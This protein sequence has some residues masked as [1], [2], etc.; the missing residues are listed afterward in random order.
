MLEMEKFWKHLKMESMVVQTWL[1]K[2]SA[3][4]NWATCN[5][6]HSFFPDKRYARELYTYKFPVG[7]TADPQENYRKWKPILC[8]PYFFLLLEKAESF[9]NC[10][11]FLWRIMTYSTTVIIRKENS[12]QIQWQAKCTAEL[13]FR[14]S[15]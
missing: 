6:V 10:L 1:P 8:K 7:N 2:N 3:H 9:N 12:K 14:S 5:S 4:V 13:T 11:L 15:H